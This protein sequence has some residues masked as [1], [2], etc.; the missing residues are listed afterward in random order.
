MYSSII[1]ID[2]EHKLTIATYIFPA[3]LQST[4]PVHRSSPV[5]VYSHISY[6]MT[7]LR[8]LNNQFP[9]WSK[10]CIPLC[11]V[12]Q[13]IYTILLFLG[14]FQRLQSTVPSPR[15]IQKQARSQIMVSCKDL[16]TVHRFNDNAC[17]HSIALLLS[18]HSLVLIF[19]LQKCTSCVMLKE[20]FKQASCDYNCYGLLTVLHRVVDAILMMS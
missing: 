5:I 7:R 12:V 6:M 11:F 4:S 17:D 2:P 9:Q 14:A 16:G 19:V 8:C 20:K 3:N 10:S 18:C 13:G 15:G 1:I